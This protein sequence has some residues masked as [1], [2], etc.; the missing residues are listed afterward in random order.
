MLVSRVGCGKV[1]RPRVAENGGFYVRVVI[2]VMEP[3]PGAPKGPATPKIHSRSHFFFFFG[4]GGHLAR[5]GTA[6]CCGNA[7]RIWCGHYIRIYL[8]KPFALPRRECK[9]AWCGRGFRVPWGLNTQRANLVRGDRAAIALTK[10]TC[11]FVG[12]GASDFVRVYAIVCVSM[13]VLSFSK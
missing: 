11:W 13:P 7:E 3:S 10:W 12:E 4:G 5:Q 2:V 1:V 6:L 9:R 8:C